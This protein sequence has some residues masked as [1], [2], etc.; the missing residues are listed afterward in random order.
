MEHARICVPPVGDQS[1]SSRA[2]IIRDRLSSALRLVD[3]IV[4]AP[5]ARPGNP[6]VTERKVRAILNQR[7]NRDQFFE[8][9]LFADPAWDIL[10]E[11]YAAELGQQRMS[12]N[13]VCEGAAVP[14]TTALRWI[15]VLERKQLIQ[16]RPDPR[17]GRRVFLSLSRTAVEAMDNYFGT[18]SDP[19]QLI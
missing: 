7:R 1:L 12:V 18:L 16:R 11:L 2:D 8:A 14:A 15:G 10:L 9:E 3:E 4:D 19:A 17:D 6:P 13:S 5:V